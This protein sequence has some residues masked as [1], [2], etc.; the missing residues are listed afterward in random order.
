MKIEAVWKPE[1]CKLLRISAEFSGPP[2]GPPQLTSIRIRGDFFFVPEESFE[3]IENGLIGLPLD[4][5]AE[6]F[7]SL[8]AGYGCMMAGI[9]G[10]GIVE[11]IRREIR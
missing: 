6:S 11:T 1:G 2:A 4:R 5:L 10:R 3:K 8:A 7:D 9:N